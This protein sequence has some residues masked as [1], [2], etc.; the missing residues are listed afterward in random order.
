MKFV[1]FL[2][3][4]VPAYGEVDGEIV[5][6][7]HG[8]PFDRHTGRPIERGPGVGILQQLT[9]LPPCLPGKVIA[10][11]RN[12]RRPDRPRPEVP[13]FFMKPPNS[14]IAHLDNI[15]Y[16]KMSQEVIHEAEVGIIIGRV[17][18]EVSVDDAPSCILG[19]TCANDVT[20]DDLIARDR[21][22][23]R[24]KAFDTFCPLGPVIVT[25]LDPSDLRITCRVNGEVRQSA[26]TAGLWFGVYEMVSF[27]S[28]ITTLLRGD[29]ILTGTPPGL[30]PLNVGDT[31]EVEVE[32]IGF[33]RN[34]VVAPS[35]RGAS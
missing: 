30:G 26:S 8:T 15:I 18:K 5:Y 27:L 3:H 1:R 7:L 6:L 33:L 34:H 11:A 2:H 16:P 22:P 29:V 14:V 23:M 13:E 9:I 25:D 28:Q 19:Y 24:G 35:I 17:T 4:G 21:L 32:G 10:A 31:V 12:W 20:A